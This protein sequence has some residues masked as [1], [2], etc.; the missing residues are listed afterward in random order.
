LTILLEQQSSITFDV[1]EVKNSRTLPPQQFLQHYLS[2]DEW[3]RPQVFAVQI[4][5]VKRDEHT[6]TTAA[7]QIT[8]DR[9]ACIIDA[10]NLAIEDGAFHAK[11]VR[12][13]CREIRKAT[14]CISVSVDQF[15]AASLDIRKRCF[16]MLFSN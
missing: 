15:T 13:P 10:C 8:E 6:L 12:D 9:S 1:I 14:E 5:Q 11:M 3:Q 7:K 16:R 2:L 4:Q